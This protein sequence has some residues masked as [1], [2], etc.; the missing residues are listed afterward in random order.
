MARHHGRGDGLAAHE[1]FGSA[2]ARLG[3]S[4]SEAGAADVR[5]PS[6]IRLR[7]R[8]IFEK[9]PSCCREAP[10]SNGVAEVSFI[11]SPSPVFGE[12]V[13]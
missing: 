1:A 11:A 2:R 7:A 3:E 10:A 6:N 12:K 8:D 9:A 5:E 4:A 13:P